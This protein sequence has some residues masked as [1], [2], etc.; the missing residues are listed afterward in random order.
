MY[1]Y[2][3]VCAVYSSFGPCR[4]IKVPTWKQC[5]G[6]VRPDY[7]SDAQVRVM[8]Y[9]PSRQLH[10]QVVSLHGCKQPHPIWLSMPLGRLVFFG[11][12]EWEDRLQCTRIVDLNHTAVESSLWLETKTS[13]ILAFASLDRTES[14]PVSCASTRTQRSWWLPRTAQST[15][16]WGHSE[17]KWR[18]ETI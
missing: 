15:P 3:H 1:M 2:D 5:V 4:L 9:G 11:A 6:P 18:I 16:T 17:R 8:Q 14:H 10:R 7:G 13:N 12:L